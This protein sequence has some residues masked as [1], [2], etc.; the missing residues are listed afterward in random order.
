MNPRSLVSYSV[1]YPISTTIRVY[2]V[3]GK[4]VCTLHAGE[5][6]GSGSVYWDGT[7]DAAAELAGG[8][9]FIRII[10][11]GFSRTAKVVLL[12]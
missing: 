4:V 5:L 12:H 6:S 8:L 10:T 11:P 7:D 3:T 9:Y 2:D 1:G